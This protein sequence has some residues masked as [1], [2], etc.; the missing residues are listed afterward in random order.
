MNYKLLL[1]IY[2]LIQSSVVS[3]FPNPE[4]AIDK[5]NAKDLEFTNKAFFHAV[6]FNR[7][8]DI[9]W[10]IKAG[11]NPNEIKN[12]NGQFAIH[13]ANG[14]RV[15]TMRLLLELGADPNVT[16]KYGNTALH[17]AAFTNSSKLL[18]MLLTEGVDINAKNS[19]GKSALHIIINRGHATI[20]EHLLRV[21]AQVN[22]EDNEG[23]TPLMGAIEAGR[24]EMISMLIKYDADINYRPTEKRAKNLTPL[25]LAIRK[26]DIHAVRILIDSG[27]DVNRTS[28]TGFT[29]IMIALMEAN[30]EI[31]ALLL[32]NK[33]QVS[34]KGG[35]KINAL[36]LC[37]KNGWFDLCNMLLKVN[38]EHA[39]SQSESEPLIYEAIR[40][41]DT[42]RLRYLFK[43]GLVADFGTTLHSR[44]LVRAVMNDD[45]ESVSLLIRNGVDVNWRE[46]GTGQSIAFVLGRSQMTSKKMLEILLKSQ[47]DLNIAD[48]AGRT[49][50]MIAAAS[51]NTDTLEAMIHAGANIDVMNKLSLTA[52]DLAVRAGRI[53]NVKAL[54]NAGAKLY[55]G[56]TEEVTV[57][58]IE[59]T[60][61]YKS[62][63]QYELK[64]IESLLREREDR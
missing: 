57:G 35:R 33:A 60:Q 37:V 64:H 50:L 6:S 61:A 18:G 30:S 14:T 32:D 44:P 53:Q 11:M 1:I 51:G 13:V 21:G 43:L 41:Q 42:D 39:I 15:D 31:I 46:P 25:I 10:F 9:K 48:I 12:E 16:D 19:R 2:L 55:S 63:I 8:D 23:K 49:P 38:N 17:S 4:T 59:T 7:H 36:Q 62:A 29:P 56:S 26:N 20:L 34:H 45:Y 52:L 24:H 3:G 27:V 5:I 28:P 47:L 40:R 54:L 22:E 58:K